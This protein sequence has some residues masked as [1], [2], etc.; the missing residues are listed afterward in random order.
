MKAQ[1]ILVGGRLIPNILTVIYQQPELIVAICSLQSHK[2]EW[3]QLKKAIQN[4][5][6]SCQIEEKVVDGYLL[7]KIEAACESWIGHST[8]DEENWIFNITNATSIMSIGAYNVAKRYAQK[9]PVS[10]W[11]LDTPRNRVIALIGEAV[12]KRIFNLKV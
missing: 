10:C 12:D 11:Y 3:P 5:V 6:P 1:L 7:D 2:R 9:V 4:L 8:E